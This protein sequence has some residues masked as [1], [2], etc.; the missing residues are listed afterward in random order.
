MGRSI[1]RAQFVPE[2][3]RVQLSWKDKYRD[4]AFR[5]QSY[6]YAIIAVPFSK[7]RTWRFP[8]TSESSV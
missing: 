5:N 8:N 6:D 7:V 2:T 4:I 1:E 3:N